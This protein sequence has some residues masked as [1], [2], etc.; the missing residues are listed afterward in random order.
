[1]QLINFLKSHSSLRHRQLREFLRET[2]A[3]YTD[4]LT[5]NDVRWLSKG[6]ALQRFWTLMDHVKEF[7]REI[8]SNTARKY[9]TQLSCDTFLS[10]IAFLTDLFEHLNVLNLKLQGEKQ[11][12]VD[13]WKEIES[14]KRKLQLFANDIKG[15][16]LHFPILKSF[17]E[18]HPISEEHLNEF[19]AFINSVLLEFMERF[20][21]FESISNI[22]KLVENPKESLWSQRLE[23]EIKTCFPDVP[24]AALQLELCDVAVETTQ[25][26]FPAEKFPA[27]TALAMPVLTIFPSTYLCEALFSK[28]NFIKSEKRTSLTNEH[29]NDLLRLV[30]HG[31]LSEQHYKA[32]L[33]TKKVFHTSH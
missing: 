18:A 10:R 32:V 19:L 25:V 5:H 29:L 13:L 12:A 33:N 11:T 30:N 6:K 9:I 2:N 1:M 20:K 4:L 31:N 15:D 28:M 22:L 21:Q 16:M 8:G 27:L 26:Y 23:K 14:F 24:I 3:E 7:L 17:Y